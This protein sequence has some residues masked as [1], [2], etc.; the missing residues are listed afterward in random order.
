MIFS[1]WDRAI[2]KQIF[3]KEAAIVFAVKRFLVS[4]DNEYLH[5]QFEYTRSRLRIARASAL[6]FAITTLLAF[7]F[8][9]TQLQ[10][11]SHYV[12]LLWFIAIVGIFLTALA[13]ITWY[14]LINS[15][16]KHI[17]INVD[18]QE[19]ENYVTKPKTE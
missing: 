7:I 14:K 18:T 9:A 8:V 13:I 16:C 3:G 5:Y 19:T 10:H 4:K 15:Y 11:Y 2:S 6:N 1:K 12:T 17:K